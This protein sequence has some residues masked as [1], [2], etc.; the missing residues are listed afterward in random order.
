M[1]PT[2]HGI[3]IEAE[4]RDCVIEVYIND[5]AIGLCG[6]GA[7]TQLTAP[8]HEF[9][10]DGANELALLVNPGDSPQT[11]T[12]YSRWHSPAFGAQPP[13]DPLLDDFIANRDAE[14][15]RDTQAQT[16]QPAPPNRRGLEARRSAWAR[17][18]LSRYPAG[19]MS[20]SGAGQ[21][22]VDVNWR[23]ADTFDFLRQEKQP[24][25]RWVRK[26]AD[27]GPMFGR[28]HWEDAVTLRLDEPTIESALEFVAHVRDL[29]ELG[30]AAPILDVSKQ[31]F[32]EVARVYGI[33]A[34]ERAAMFERLLNEESEKPHWIFET[35][36]E[37]DVDLRLCA[38]GR[39][40]ECIGK[41]W[42]S[43]IRGVP[44][45]DENQFMFPM[46]IGR[47]EPDGDWLIMR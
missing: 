37:D 1:D 31:K 28:F 6:V 14:D 19:A 36:D 24:F 16:E 44:N 34:D 47:L 30:I 4:V 27:L 29:V 22:L 8:V 25:P 9:L 5:I 35:P 15:S 13:M 39:M 17:V 2:T 3:V 45:P 33:S 10:L 42:K 46:K 12:D 23:A 21:S 18:Q 20:G 11:A 43:S 38:D 40:I 26:F 7:S 32:D 41:D